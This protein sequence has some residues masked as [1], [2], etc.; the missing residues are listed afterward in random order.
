MSIQCM[1]LG[2][3]QFSMFQAEETHAYIRKWLKEN[4]SEK[5]RALNV[6]N[7]FSRSIMTVN[8]HPSTPPLPTTRD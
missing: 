4:V 8:S 1:N 2:K 7:G 6:G 5:A 3:R